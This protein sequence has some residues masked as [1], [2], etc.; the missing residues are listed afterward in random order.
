[1]ARMNRLV[2]PGLPHHLVLRAAGGLQ[3][4]RDAQDYQTYLEMLAMQ[5]KVHAVDLH[6]Y[7]LLEDRLHLLLTPGHEHSIGRLM[8]S[9]GRRYVRYF[10]ERHQRYGTL[11]EG[12]FRAGPMQPGPY[13]LAT[14]VFMDWLPV[15][16]QKVLEVAA[17][18]WS[19]HRHYAGL[20]GTQPQELLRARM[21]TAHAAYWALA[22]T[23]FGRE[24][25]YRQQVQQGQGRAEAERIERS[26]MGSWLLGE[27]D[28]V[29][30]MS[31]RHEAGRRLLPGKPGRPRKK[32]EEAETPL[33][34]KS[35]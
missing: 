15:R 31:T 2:L 24:N 17:W 16:A 12:R 4:F 6:A 26:A 3:A 5:L 35:N 1:M 8:Q 14:M 13:V 21:L 20:E 28:F 23:P 30:D 25:A 33:N 27:A 7:V 18:P 11:W 29:Q 10:N 22:D 34:N 9:M 19:S 32:H